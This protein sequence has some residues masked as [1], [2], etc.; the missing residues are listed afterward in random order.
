MNVLFKG[1]EYRVDVH[2]VY[3]TVDNGGN[4]CI[5]CGTLVKS[6]SKDIHFRSRHASESPRYGEFLRDIGEKER[7]KVKPLRSVNVS[8]MRKWFDEH[9]EN[10]LN[11][12]G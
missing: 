10:K 3:D 8:D 7:I 9:F 6:K 1:K 2:D 4:R 12:R 11:W 5:I